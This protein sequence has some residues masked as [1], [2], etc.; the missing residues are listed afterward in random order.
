MVP[1]LP[2][3]GAIS[4]VATTAWDT[5]IRI[6]RVRDGMAASKRTVPAD[7]ALIARIEQLEAACLEQA[8]LVSDLSKELEQFARAI[9]SRYALLRKAV[10]VGIGV[11]ILC[12]SE[13]LYL[14]LK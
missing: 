7:D 4:N 3:L 9:E 14:L 12:A 10:W 8:Q 6:R 13:V 11:A 2:I 5:Y 1:I